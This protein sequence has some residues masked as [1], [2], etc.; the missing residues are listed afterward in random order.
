MDL[1]AA[2]KT[3]FGDCVADILDA[4]QAASADRR[5]IPAN[6]F[7]ADASTACCRGWGGRSSGYATTDDASDHAPIAALERFELATSML[8]R[9]FENAEYRARARERGLEGGDEAAAA[10]REVGALEEELRVKDALLEK[11]ARLLKE[12]EEKL[13]AEGGA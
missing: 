4:G 9:Y 12:W 11:S 10:Q 8:Q 7:D 3:S 13:L 6:S 5:T 2:V 1:L